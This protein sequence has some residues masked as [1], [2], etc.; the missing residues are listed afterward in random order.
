MA[1]TAHRIHIIGSH[2]RERPGYIITGSSHGSTSNT[3]SQPDDSGSHPTTF[4]PLWP[5]A[6]PLARMRNVYFRSMSN[7]NN[8]RLGALCHRCFATAI[9]LLSDIQGGPGH[10]G[11]LAEPRGCDGAPFGRRL[12]P[13]GGRTM[14]PAYDVCLVRSGV[15]EPDYRNIYYLPPAYLESAPW[16]APECLTENL[17]Y[18]PDGLNESAADRTVILLILCGLT[19]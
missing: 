19:E 6:L 4:H 5:P 16:P 17:L 12:H 11:Y 1:R 15:T 14:R 18:P 3:Q 10:S 2:P 8:Q 13:P 9:P 7:G